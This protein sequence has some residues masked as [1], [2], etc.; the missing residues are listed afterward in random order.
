MWAWAGARE[1]RRLAG[2]PSTS[3]EPSPTARATKV[4][5]TA[6]GFIF[7]NEV[8]TQESG[9]M[10]LSSG[11]PSPAR[12]WRQGPG[13]VLFNLSSGAP[14]D[15]LEAAH[16]SRFLHGSSQAGAGQIKLPSLMGNSLLCD[17]A[18]PRWLQ[19]IHGRDSTR[20]TRACLREGGEK[21]RQKEDGG[22]ERE[23]L[24]S[25]SVRRRHSL[26]PWVRKIPWRSG[27]TL[28]FL[29]EKSHGQRSLAGYSPWGHKG[30]DMTER[31]ITHTHL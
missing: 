27:I 22:G 18:G 2:G 25:V 1:L 29:L 4:P 23:H 15:A 6:E 17:R 16:T 11:G 26:H 19:N 31:L 8:E 5:D 28:V 10:L 12:G 3:E 14:A 24:L 30:W 7:G 9:P 21:E 13:T 20:E